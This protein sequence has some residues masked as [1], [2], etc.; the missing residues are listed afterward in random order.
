MYFN[1]PTLLTPGPTPVTA[2]IQAE[3][4]LPM[5]GHRSS[6]FEM[7][8]KEAFQA[9]KVVFGSQHD[10]MILSSS[11]TSALEASMVNLLEAEDHVVVIVSGAFG[12]RFKQIAQTYY[13][14]VHVFDVTWGEAFDTKA[15]IDF[16]KNINHRIKAV[17]TQFCE[18]STAVLHPVAELG[19]AL[20]QLDD[21]IFY[22]VD[23]VS[24]IGAVDVDMQRDAIDVLVS[25]SQKAMG[26]PPGI[27]FVAYN[28]RAL[29]AFQQNQTPKFYLDLSKHYESLKASSTPNTPN[30]T[31]FRGVNAY[32]RNVNELGLKNVIQQHYQLRDAVRSA[33]KALDLDLL[34]NDAV[35]S[36]TVTA[37]IP[38]NKEELQ[39]IKNELKAQFN[40]TIAGGQGYLKGQI[41]RVGHM[42]DVSP[43]TLLS[44]I[45][46][47]ELILTKH[48][49][50]SLVGK[51]TTAFMEV[52]KDVI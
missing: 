35:A 30:I 22:V 25:G 12:N 15:V 34:V 33:L 49:Q 14:N 43:F 21:A 24:C 52:L 3:M 5:V 29:R 39:T 19:V 18:T 6:D 28:E 40:I 11:G 7:I 47:L 1:H 26:L 20:K 2:Q 31:A 27:A 44:F 51:G 50:T 36:P 23:G 37:F 17:F 10:V 32:M 38:K 8:A 16:I 46:A 13:S 45:A 9:L 42:A 41:L 4:N 48:R